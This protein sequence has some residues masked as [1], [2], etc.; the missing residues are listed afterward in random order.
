WR[1]HRDADIAVSTIRLDRDERGSSMTADPTFRVLDLSTT[2][3]GAYCAHLLA[4]GDIEV[5]HAEPPGAHALR[6]WSA[7][8]APIPDGAAGALFQWLAGGTR[9]VVV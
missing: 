9:S 2:L 6:R 1:P 4:S 3:A 8:G 7:V 5:T